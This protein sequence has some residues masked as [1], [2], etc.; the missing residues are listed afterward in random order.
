MNTQSSASSIYPARLMAFTHGPSEH[1]DVPQEHRELPQTSLSVNKTLS[2]YKLHNAYL[3]PISLCIAILD[4][5]Q[6][7]H[8]SCAN[9]PLTTDTT[10][11]PLAESA[12]KAFT[13]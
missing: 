10:V 2:T 12:P 1:D 5:D 11:S 13:S 7:R 3:A 8:A 6:A 4:R 9:G